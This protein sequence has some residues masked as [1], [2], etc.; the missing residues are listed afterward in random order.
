MLDFHV[1]TL[2]DKRWIDE[3]FEGT[4]YFGCFCTFAT[5][6]L[7]RERYFTE[8]ARFGDCLL[9]RGVDDEKRLYY[10]YPMGKRYDVRAAVAALR[11][12]AAANGTRL[13]FYCVENWQCDELREAFPGEFEFKEQRGDFDYLYRSEDLIRLGGKKYHAKRNHISKFIRSYPDWKYENIDST[14]I[15]ACVEFLSAQLE[16][17][18]AGQDG[19]EV[20]EL[21]LENTAIAKALK[22]FDILKMEGGLLRAGGRVIA[23]TIGEPLNRRVFVTHFEKADTDYDG[24]Y[25]MINQ[26]F[27]LNRLSGYEYINRE[28]DMGKEGLRKAKLSYYPVLLL[29]KFS[30]E[31]VAGIQNFS[32][33]QG[34]QGA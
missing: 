6:W 2:E 1:P 4:G 13:L 8:V 3:I 25:T 7:W 27:A 20:T 5:L 23:V 17:A 11:G 33:N 29:E 24:A 15:P 26:Q 16:R 18:I 19:E 22:N 32:D 9:I 10:M 12:D 21:C 14:N 34:E 31:D 28:E 30:A